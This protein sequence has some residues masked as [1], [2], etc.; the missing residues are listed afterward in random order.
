MYH[1]L[2]STPK[3][4]PQVSPVCSAVLLSNHYPNLF[5]S[6]ET[7]LASVP[8]LYHNCTHALK[9][10][11]FSWLGDATGLSFSLFWLFP[12]SHLFPI[13]HDHGG[14][15]KTQCEHFTAA[16]MSLSGSLQPSI[17]LSQY[18]SECHSRLR[19][20]IPWLISAVASSAVYALRLGC[21]IFE[22]FIVSRFYPVSVCLFSGYCLFLKHSSPAV[23]VSYALTW[24][25]FVCLSKSS[26]R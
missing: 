25:T 15:S 19:S 20:F 3:G 22:L 26:P 4:T 9:A 11:L 10:P 2:Y 14:F 24:L 23:L 8:S 13:L 5:I 7:P 18:S 17:D 21:S 1:N 16:H 12:H 6:S